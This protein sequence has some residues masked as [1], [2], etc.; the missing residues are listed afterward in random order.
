MII[1]TAS[2]GS[3]TTFRWLCGFFVGTRCSG[4]EVHQCL[5]FGTRRSLVRQSTFVGLERL[6]HQIHADVGRSE[7]S[8][9][10]YAN[11]HLL[12]A[13]EDSGIVVAPGGMRPI[14]FEPS[15]DEV[16][17]SEGDSRAGKP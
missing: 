1:S 12:E 13:L 11:I 2:D 14:P 8:D 5:L 3:M 4:H 16:I 7:S 9:L 10:S 17:V 15:S 6:S